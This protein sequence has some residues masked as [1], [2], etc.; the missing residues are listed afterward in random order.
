MQREAKHLNG[1]PQ[2]GELKSEWIL[3]IPVH[4]SFFNAAEN[5]TLS[6]NDGKD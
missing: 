1:F 3:H 4:G 6:T 5:S 2:K